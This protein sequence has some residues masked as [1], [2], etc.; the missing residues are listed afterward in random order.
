M[1]TPSNETKVDFRV[2]FVLSKHFCNV[3]N[4]LPLCLHLAA[5]TL[6]NTVLFLW[7]QMEGPLLDET[8]CES[9][10]DC[11]PC[12][13]SVMLNRRDSNDNIPRDLLREERTQIRTKHIELLKMERKNTV[14]DN[15][16]RKYYEEDWRKKC[17]RQ[18][19][20]MFWGFVGFF[21]WLVR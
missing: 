4:T 9:P 15:K 19:R 6:F 14:G 16:K 18:R 3:N 11:F 17:I 12:T 2:I 1:R 8:S 21:F 13:L 7:I 10:R 20:R 5:F